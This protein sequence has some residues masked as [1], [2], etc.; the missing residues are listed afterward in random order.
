MT[1]K[2]KNDE[3][4]EVEFMTQEEID[5]HTTAKIEE[6]KKETLTAYEAEKAELNKQL[7]EAQEALARS[8]D[9][10]YNF[11]QLR[12]TVDT[13]KTAKE[14]LENKFTT[15]LTTLKKSLSQKTIDGFIK[16]ESAGDEDVAKKLKYHYEKTLASMPEGTEEEIKAK[17]QSASLLAGKPVSNGNTSFV[18]SSGA[19]NGKTK[20]GGKLT[21]DQMDLASKLGIE[22]DDIKKVIK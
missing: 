11:S 18:S 3:G 19:G 12:K 10:D 6:A 7:K 16:Q 1:I 22:E 20:T 5:A 9:K 2:L 21:A 17:V 14:E 15:E 13:L 8:G 4:E